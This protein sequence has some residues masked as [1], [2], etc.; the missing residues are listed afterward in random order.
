MIECI[1]LLEIV[2][3]SSV[4][5]PLSGTVH[6]YIHA[7]IHTGLPRGVWGPGAVRRYGSLCDTTDYTIDMHHCNQGA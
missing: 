3:R 4:T 1:H 2:M 7:Y 5:L 6:A